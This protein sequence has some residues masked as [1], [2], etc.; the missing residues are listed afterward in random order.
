ME[1]FNAFWLLGR[2]PAKG[3]GNTW[4]GSGVPWNQPSP[5][6]TRGTAPLHPSAGHWWE[7]LRARGAAHE[8]HVSPQQLGRA[9]RGVLER[10]KPLLV[11][12]R[13]QQLHAGM[14]LSSSTWCQ[15]LAFPR[16]HPRGSPR[17]A[18]SAE[19]RTSRGRSCLAPGGYR[20]AKLYA[21]VVQ[22]PPSRRQR[23]QSNA[24]G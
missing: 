1:P 14:C 8:P 22:L 10:E 18:G 3:T 19:G 24:H 21:L 4:S 11:T 16:K 13:L 23:Q 17:A 5:Q 12:Q 7:G 6:G 15:R 9:G 2:A 20:R